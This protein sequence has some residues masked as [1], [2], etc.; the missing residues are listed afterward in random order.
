MTAI[1]TEKMG[2]FNVDNFISTLRNVDQMVYVFIGKD[3]VWNV[4]DVS[5]A[6]TISV[7][8][9]MEDSADIVSMKRIFYSDIS[10]IVKKN[11]WAENTVYHQYTDDTDLSTLNYFVE[12]SNHVFKCISNNGGLESTVRPSSVNDYKGFI[13]TSDNYIWKYMYSIL[14]GITNT[15]DWTGDVIDNVGAQSWMPAKDIETRTEN[16]DQWDEMKSAVDGSIYGFNITVTGDQS[17]LITSLVNDVNDKEV[18][19]ESPDGSGFKGVFRATETSVGSGTY[20]FVIDT[21]GTGLSGG[22]DYNII[23]GITIDGSLNDVQGTSYIDYMKPIFSP[24]GG[25]GYDPVREL[26]GEF[27]L[28][29]ATVDS[30]VGKYRKMGIIV[31]PLRKIKSDRVKT[32]PVCI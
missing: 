13:K 10:Y 4:L 16:S 24:I 30:F 20:V 31:N 9:E 26:G 22:K 15:W 11:S 18:L 27:V 25:H 2:F 19:L 23:T 28:I 1:I 12:D 21:V 29:K 32:M 6:P 3:D 8:R 5:P 17:S 7:R 14:D